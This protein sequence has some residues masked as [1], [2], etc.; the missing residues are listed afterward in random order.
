MQIEAPQEKLVIPGRDGT[1][2]MVWRF[3]NGPIC[4]LLAPGLGTPVISWKYIVERFHRNFTIIT[5]DAR[6]N[7]E[8]GT[9]ED[10]DRLRI[11]DHTADLFA[12]AAYFKIG[13]FVLGGWSM[14]VQISLEAYHQQPERI[15]ALLLINGAPGRLLSTAYP[16]P[17]FEPLAVRLLRLAHYWGNGMKKV[18]HWTLNRSWSLP[19]MKKMQ[20]FTNN[21][22]F[23]IHMVRPFSNLDFSVY[24]HMML[25]V[26][27]HTAVPYLPEIR[28]PTLVTAG[29]KDLM[30]PV[31]TARLIADT[32]EKAELFIVPNGTHYTIAE[33][34]EILNLRLERFFRDH[35]P[36]AKIK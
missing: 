17:G 26:N 32:I 6:G 16:I 20:I 28:V 15:Q 31:S 25:L 11:E 23:F 19:V 10:L 1:P 4:L 34:P 27:E 9:P 14:G 30:T 7:H 29:T 5:W 2:L 13:K 18:M 36:A 8:S 33:Y 24:F 21:D 3:G 35:V 22:D 12:I